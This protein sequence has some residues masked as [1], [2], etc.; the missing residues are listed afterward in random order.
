MKRP[1]WEAIPCSQAWIPV[2]NEIQ[3]AIFQRTDVRFDLSK[4]ERIKRAAVLVSDL[5]DYVVL[6][7]SFFHR[8]YLCRNRAH[9]GLMFL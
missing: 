7:R 4:G 6:T 8:D 9:K 3:P 2:I 5:H 1:K